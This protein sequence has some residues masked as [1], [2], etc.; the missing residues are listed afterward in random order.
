[1]AFTLIILGHLFILRRK[2]LHL[3]FSRSFDDD[4][5]GYVIAWLA[6]KAFQCL[7]EG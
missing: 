4:I 3:R 5:Y 7:A 6:V 1:M 2:L